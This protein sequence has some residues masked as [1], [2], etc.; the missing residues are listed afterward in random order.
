[1]TS[2]ISDGSPTQPAFKSPAP[3]APILTAGQPREAKRPNS[4]VKQTQPAVQPPALPANPDRNVNAQ[5]Y[6]PCVKMVYVVLGRYA[7]INYR[8]RACSRGCTHFLLCAFGIGTDTEMII[9]EFLYIYFSNVRRACLLRHKFR[10]THLLWLSAPVEWWMGAT[11]S[12]AEDERHANPILRT[13][14]EVYLESASEFYRTCFGGAFFTNRI[15]TNRIRLLDAVSTYL[16]DPFEMQY[17]CGE[18]S[19]SMRPCVRTGR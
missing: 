17:T 18:S 8:L 10:V 14:I 19:F 16:T 4:D 9:R 2:T 11:D 3:H 1:M 15:R 5:G 7:Q 12:E 13:P 6:Q